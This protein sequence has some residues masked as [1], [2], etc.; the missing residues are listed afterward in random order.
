MIF[1]PKKGIPLIAANRLQRWSLYL[2]AFQYKIQYVKAQDNTVP[3]TLSRLPLKAKDNNKVDKENI[4][5]NHIVENDFIKA[6]DVARE[7][8]E[9]R[10]CGRVIR[11]IRDGWPENVKQVESELQPFHNRRNEL[12]VEGDC[13]FGDIGY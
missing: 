12:S 13:V 11:T 3:D 4:N 1:G 5:I 6:K 7:T 8:K 9:D 2:S 10:I